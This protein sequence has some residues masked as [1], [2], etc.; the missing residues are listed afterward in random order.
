MMRKIK[1]LNSSNSGFTIVELMISTVVFSMVLMICSYAIIYIGQVYYKGVVTNRTQEASRKIMN[2]LVYS[3]Q[4]GTVQK[5]THGSIE[6]VEQFPG[7]SFNVESI[8]LGG[9]KYSYTKDRS[10]GEGEKQARHVLWKSKAN[11]SDDCVVSDLSQPVP[12]GS[13]LDGELLSSNMRVP[14]L[15]V[16]EPADTLSGMWEIEVAVS[17]GDDEVFKL[18]P[19]G[20]RDYTLCEGVNAGGQFC[21]VSTYKTTV[22]KRLN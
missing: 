10:L 16:R 6:P 20:T 1:S 2:D 19:D 18:N 3:I 8:C 11:S 14:Y 21:A 17:Y 12:G 4:F 13:N 7:E 15:N 22:Q 9:F 5:V